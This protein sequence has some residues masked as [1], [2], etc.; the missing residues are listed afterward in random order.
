MDKKHFKFEEGN[1][2]LMCSSL[3]NVLVLWCMSQKNVILVIIM[4]DAN[5]ISCKIFGHPNMHSI[6]AQKVP[7]VLTNCDHFVCPLVAPYI[8]VPQPPK[9]LPYA[10]SSPILTRF[11]QGLQVPPSW[12]HQHYMVGIREVILFVHFMCFLWSSHFLWH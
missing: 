10:K 5:E 9:S 7:I 4:C 3:L 1:Y 8:H 2:L 6:L 12:E 11:L